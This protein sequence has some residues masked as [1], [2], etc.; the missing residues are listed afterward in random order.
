MYAI[1]SY[2]AQVAECKL[3]CERLGRVPLIAAA[4]GIN[5][6]NAGDYAAAG[7]D[8]LVTSAPYWAPPKDVQVRFQPGE[9]AA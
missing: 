3:G 5:A 6:T 7:A 8:L 1:R 4:G 2:Y 9:G